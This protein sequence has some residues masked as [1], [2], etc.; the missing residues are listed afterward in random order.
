MVVPPAPA[1]AAQ[2]FVAAAV[3]TQPVAVLTDGPAAVL[4]EW[5]TRI[6]TRRKQ[7]LSEY[8]AS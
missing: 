6:H 8:A 1:A 3:S 5:L 2:V 4:E 7:I